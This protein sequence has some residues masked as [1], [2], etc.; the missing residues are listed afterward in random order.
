MS[1]GAIIEI[2][3]PKQWYKQGVLFISIAFSTG[4]EILPA[5]IDVL[6]AA[7]SFSLLASC[8][9]TFNDILDRKE[10]SNHPEK[11]HRPI[12]SGRI[13]INQAILT[14]LVLL[15]LSTI[16]G[17][18]FVNRIFLIILGAYVL[19]NILYNIYAKNVFYVD[20]LFVSFGFALRAVSGVFAIDKTISVWLVL[21]TFL[22]ATVLALTKRLKEDETSENPEQSRN[23]M[24]KYSKV[25]IKS[26]LL[27]HLSALLISYL[28]YT[29]I[30]GNPYMMATIPFSLYAVVRYY[31]LITSDENI[32][33]PTDILLND[34][35]SVINLIIWG[36]VIYTVIHTGYINLVPFERFLSA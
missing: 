30:G 31:F 21:C 11:K 7:L 13:S 4:I 25:N 26:I 27:V 28:L 32:W 17:Y 10:D 2:M 15:L 24:N 20:V 22:L 1:F 36:F 34:K 29:S 8:I 23:V 35:G 9:Y 12:P 6:F 5:F 33:S 18:Y 3:R 19:Q 16:L 14:G